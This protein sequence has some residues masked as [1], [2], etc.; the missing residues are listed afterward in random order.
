MHNLAFDISHTLAGGL[1]LISFMML[2]QDRLYSLL[3][4][5]AL[6]AVV[7][8]L[9]VAWQ[10]YIQDAPHLYVTAV[11]ALVFK[12]IVIRWRC[13][14]SPSSPAFIAT[15]RRPGI[16][17]PCWPG[18][19]WSPSMVLMLRAT[20]DADPL[21]ARISPSPCRSCCSDCWSW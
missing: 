2:Y 6:H 20:A 21:R 1:V 19:D 5:F 17:R 13:T 4:V 18:W 3:N 8:S 16:G 15:S 11:I 10:A 9:S 14:A 7:L 12:A